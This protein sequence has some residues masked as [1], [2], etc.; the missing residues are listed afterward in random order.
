[1]KILV[2]GASGM[3]G[4]SML[5]VMSEN[6]KLDVFGTVR[7][8]SDKKF[9]T[10]QIKD[11]VLHNVN[12]ENDKTLNG[13]FVSL[14]PNVVINCVGIV[15]QI[16]EANSPLKSIAI[17]SL[18]PHKLKSLCDSFDSRLIHISTDCV[19]S[20]KYGMYKEEDVSDCTDFYGKTK[21]LGEVISDRSL[22]IRTSIIGPELKTN[23]GLFNWF[24]SQGKE[25]NGYSN[26]VF[27]G[28]PTVVLS[29]ILRDIIIHDES[30]SGL[31]N[32]AS[33][34][35]SK[36]DLLRLIAD[37]YKKDIKIN[38]YKDFTIDRSLDGSKFNLK[39]GYI[40]PNWES[41][42]NTMRGINV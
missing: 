28:F 6:K 19:F 40:I 31:Y 23:H 37:I 4:S 16:D 42:I 30:I 27:S 21:Y 25:C 13:L 34:K 9:F 1:M 10:Q 14:K 35:I 20:G 8:K 41:M 3:L 5:N 12:I 18:F 22:T 36:F 39:S 32:I 33:E 15:K 38:D 26:A 2:L 11:K 29:Q 24:L 7:V 17:N